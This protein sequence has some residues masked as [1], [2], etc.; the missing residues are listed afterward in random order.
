MN[1]L[2]TNVS[3]MTALQALTQTQQSLSTTEN[4]IS[5]GLAISSAAD[6]A[7]YWSIATKMSSDVGALGA[8]QSALS[9]SSSMVSTMSAAMTATISVMDAIKNDL[10]TA[11]NPGSDLTKIQTDI[12]AQ[13]S[14]LQSIGQ[15][16]NFNGVNF[17]NTTG[18][19]VSL[20][21]SYDSTNGVSTININTANTML[22]SIAAGASPTSSG[23]GILDKAGT[24]Y[25]SA[26][27]MTLNVSSATSGDIANMLTDVNT[28]INSITTAGS[29]L[30]ANSTNIA[31]QQNFISNLSNSLTS[32][33]GSLVDA[34]MNQASTKLAALQVQQQLGIQALSIANTNTQMI[35]K[36]FGG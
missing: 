23:T 31:T 2:L 33:I 26:S 19:T 22:F 13:Q 14:L 20:V 1:S 16:A 36:L 7:S 18:S 11:S 12:S 27:I 4:Q 28:A 17:L 24:A 15:S 3:A 25:S 30:G 9:E 29:T 5:T 35:L 32:G 8:V 34:D 10:V 6:N 21:A